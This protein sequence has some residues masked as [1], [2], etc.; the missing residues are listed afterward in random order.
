MP[1]SGNILVTRGNVHEKLD[2]K[3]VIIAVDKS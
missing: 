3:R 2:E 1:F